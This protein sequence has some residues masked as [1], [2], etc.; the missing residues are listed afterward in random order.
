MRRFAAAAV[1]VVACMLLPRAAAV[2]APAVTPA[3][4]VVPNY[5]GRAPLSSRFAGSS[6]TTSPQKPVAKVIGLIALAAALVFF[7]E[8]FGILGGRVRN[9][10]SRPPRTQDE[11]S[12]S[13]P[14]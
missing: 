10:S 8:G 3:P 1:V 9:L 13:S 2:A 5:T 12:R 7:S 11:R 4:S 6:A 14:A